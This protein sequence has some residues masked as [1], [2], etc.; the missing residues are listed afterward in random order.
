L[1]PLPDL[2]KCQVQQVVLDGCMALEEICVGGCTLLLPEPDS[3]SAEDGSE[4]LLF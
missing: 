1:Q 2:S 4:R 3:S